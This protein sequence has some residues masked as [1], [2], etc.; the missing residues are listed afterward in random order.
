MEIRA[1]QTAIQVLQ[2]TYRAP[3][4]LL[5]H[6]LS[7]AA[8]G[9]SA[10]HQRCF[11]YSYVS[12]SLCIFI[13]YTLSGNNLLT[14]TLGKFRYIVDQGLNCR[15]NDCQI[16]D[17]VESP[18]QN[19]NCA[20]TLESGMAFHRAVV[21]ASDYVIDRPALAMN[22]LVVHV[23][24]GKSCYR[25]C[26]LGY[27]MTSGNGRLQ[28]VLGVRRTSDR[29]FFGRTLNRRKNNTHSHHCVELHRP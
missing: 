15:A 12:V 29:A 9:I 5:D 19:G 4:R 24:T 10:L 18:K 1:V 2:P 17:Q 26:A 11:T 7:L 27:D 14:C 28:C 25:S 23:C 3:D 13:G 8:V 16:S 22:L 21:S 20:A 6:L